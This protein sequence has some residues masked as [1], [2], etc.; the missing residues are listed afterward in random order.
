M[1]TTRL[2][3]AAAYAIAIEKKESTRWQPK[4]FLALS[5][6]YVEVIEGMREASDIIGDFKD[7]SGREE[8]NVPSLIESA[9]QWLNHW[10]D[11]L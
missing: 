11:L 2:K 1:S 4:E 9:S 7:D 8:V 5:E 10:K 3:L 6:A